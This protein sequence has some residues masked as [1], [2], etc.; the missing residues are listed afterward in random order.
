MQLKCKCVFVF[1]CSVCTPCTVALKCTQA[2]AYSLQHDTARTKHVVAISGDGPLCLCVCVTCAGHFAICMHV[3]NINILEFICAADERSTRSFASAGVLCVCQRPWWTQRT[4]SPFIFENVS[5]EFRGDQ[6]QTLCDDSVAEWVTGVSV[7]CHMGYFRW[8]YLFLHCILVR[9]FLYTMQKANINAAALVD[10]HRCLRTVPYVVQLFRWRNRM[11][12]GSFRLLV[13][14][15]KPLNNEEW[16]RQSI[17]DYFPSQQ[18]RSGWHDQEWNWPWPYIKNVQCTETNHSSFHRH[19]PLLITILSNE[20]NRRVGRASQ[21]NKTRKKET[22]NDNCKLKISFI[23]EWK[24]FYI[25]W[26]THPT[27]VWVS[28]CVVVMCSFVDWPPVSLAGI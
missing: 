19:S 20:S 13:L 4:M 14:H 18:F 24:W 7:C 28:V 26:N 23:I 8:L 27:H 5:Y 10:C 17:D 22:R 2:Q 21:P 3:E 12:T 9:P 6:T 1:R 15:S 16:F 25:Q 11:A